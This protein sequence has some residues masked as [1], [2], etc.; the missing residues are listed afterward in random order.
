MIVKIYRKLYSL[1]SFYLIIL[2]ISLPLVVNLSLV[3]IDLH[4]PDLLSPSTDDYNPMQLII[5]NP[6]LIIPALIV[7]PI[8]ETSIQYIPVK[9]STF[10]LNK[11]KYLSLLLSTLTFA[12]LH[13]HE[14]IYFLALG[15][16]GFIWSTLCLVFI[17]KKVFSPYLY[18][19]FI[20]SC[21]NSV[22]LLID[23]IIIYR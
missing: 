9:I 10:F 18:V 4:F 11:G 1:N 3:Y 8:I 21:Y 19:A 6:L 23:Y 5:D 7:G 17:K 13:R 22:L 15:F 16:A 20:H 14:L 2:G 12:L